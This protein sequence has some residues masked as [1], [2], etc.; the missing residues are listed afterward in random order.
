MLFLNHLTINADVVNSSFF[1]KMTIVRAVAML[2]ALLH[3][4]LATPYSP[5]EGNTMIAYPYILVE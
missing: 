2:L 5:C 3:G 4:V 1:A